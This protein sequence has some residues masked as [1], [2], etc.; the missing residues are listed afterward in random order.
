[1]SSGRSSSTVSYIGRSQGATL[2]PPVS[3]TMSVS[4][5][6]GQTQLT[7]TPWL[8]ASGAHDRVKC[9]IAAL[10]AT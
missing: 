10:V 8:S 9:T 3:C 6:P 5:S 2:S 1:M 4:V 7:R